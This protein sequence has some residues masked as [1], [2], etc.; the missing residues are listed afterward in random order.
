[1]LKLKSK[2]SLQLMLGAFLL[3]ALLFTLVLVLKQTYPF[4]G[5]SL[6]RDDMNYQY[7]SYFAYFKRH[8]GD[9]SAFLYSYNMTLGGNFLGLTSYYLLSPFNLI[10]LLFPIHQFPLAIYIITMLKLSF[11]GLNM[12]LLLRFQQKQLRT[13]FNLASTNHISP[14]LF[15]TAYAMMSYSMVYS[16]DIMWLDVVMLLPIVILGIERQLAGHSSLLYLSMLFLSLIFNYYIGFMV[17]LFAASY[18]VFRF[19][20]IKFI[21]G[22]VAGQIT[23]M[24]RR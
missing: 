10:L 2:R 18:F 19:I 14:L 23:T 4:G 5:A 12:V 3:P 6:L 8:F 7:V 11:A 16:L 1:M 9:L 13:Y 20:Q 22:L 17:C 15:S 24:V 21:Y